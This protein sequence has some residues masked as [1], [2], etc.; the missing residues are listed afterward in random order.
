MLVK[1]SLVSRVYWLASGSF[2][3]VFIAALFFPEQSI[4]VFWMQ[5]P[6]PSHWS[7]D[8]Q[9]LPSS[10]VVPSGA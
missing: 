3:Q 5:A 1:A 10:Q 7:S 4:A 8:E 2:V 9:K 6:L